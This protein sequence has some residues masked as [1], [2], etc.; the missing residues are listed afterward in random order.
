M[1]GVMLNMKNMDK[2]CFLFGDMLIVV[3]IYNPISKLFYKDIV[4]PSK[5]KTLEIQI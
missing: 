1:Q 2:N 4:S 3:K 5:S